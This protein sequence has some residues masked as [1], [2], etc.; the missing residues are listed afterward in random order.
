MKQQITNIAKKIIPQGIRIELR[1][2]NWKLNYSLQSKGITEDQAYCPIA[3]R[4]FK[5]FVEINGLKITPSN[6]AR[7]RQRLVWHFLENELNVLGSKRR[8]LHIAPEVPYLEILSKS[9][10]I[11][12]HAGDKM[13][14]GYSNQQGVENLDLTDLSKKDNSFDLIICN[15]VLEHIPDDH[16]AMSEMFRVLKPGGKAVITIPINEKLEETYENDDIQTPKERIKH[17]GQWDHVRFYGIDIKNR[18]N[19]VGF[20]TELIRYAEQFSKED[21]AKFGFVNDYIILATKE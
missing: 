7:G 20:N 13:V 10:N 18:L 3:K 6:G 5:T 2:L 8:I 12:Y 15:H 17:F 4:G 21:Y 14:D 9:S 11:D 1:K 19:K 16:K